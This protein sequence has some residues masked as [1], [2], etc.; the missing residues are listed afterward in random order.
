MIARSLPRRLGVWAAG[1]AG[2]FLVSAL[3]LAGLAA[4]E[5]DNRFCVACHLHEEKFERLVAVTSADLAGF[6]YRKDARVGCI[7]CHGGSDL[8]RRLR[9]WA[10]AGL[11]TL[12]FLAGTYREPTRMRLPLRDADCR[13][14]HTPIL[15]RAAGAPPAYAE[16]AETEGRLGA[17]YHAIRE[18]DTVRTACVRCHPSHATDSDAQNRFIA[19]SRVQPLCRECHKQM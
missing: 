7:A 12:R 17:S 10:V 4:R 15:K 6:H 14:C 11:D 8:P 2:A 5:R 13:L 19:R 18:H 9:V 16:E 1:V 3:F